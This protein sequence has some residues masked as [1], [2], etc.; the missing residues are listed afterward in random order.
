MVTLANMLREGG[1]SPSGTSR[2][3]DRRASNSTGSTTSPSSACSMTSR[4]ATLSYDHE[5]PRPA[6]AVTR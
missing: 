1:I 3:S 4:S 2:P 6:S 5:R